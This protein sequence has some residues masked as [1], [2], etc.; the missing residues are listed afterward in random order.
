MINHVSK[1]KAEEVTEETTQSQPLIPH[2]SAQVDMLLHTIKA[3][4]HTHMHTYECTLM[5]AHKHIHYLLLLSLVFIKKI[6][7]SI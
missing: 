5:H 4:A 6:R 7:N 2:A 1:D 3:H